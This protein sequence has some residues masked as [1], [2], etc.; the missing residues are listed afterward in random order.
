[1]LSE[2]FALHRTK[3]GIEVPINREPDLSVEFDDPGQ[4]ELRQKQ[5]DEIANGLFELNGITRYRAA[6]GGGKCVLQGWGAN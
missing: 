1:L 3:G 6:C 4:P 2:P 5:F